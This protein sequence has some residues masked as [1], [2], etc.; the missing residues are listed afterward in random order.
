MWRDQEN[1]IVACRGGV[2]VEARCFWSSSK[3][4]RNIVMQAIS[5]IA[6]ENRR[7]FNRTED[8][9]F[10]HAEDIVEAVAW[11][12]LDGSVRPI[13]PPRGLDLF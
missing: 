4:Y 5:L 7:L 13:L 2:G 3:T 12:M 11:T 9:T 10:V 1:D 8:I 6:T